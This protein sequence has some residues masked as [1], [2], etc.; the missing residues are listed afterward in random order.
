[1]RG[2]QKQ[3][4]YLESQLKALKTGKAIKPNAIEELKDFM[5]KRG[6]NITKTVDTTY[7]RKNGKEV[8]ANKITFS[9]GKDYMCTSTRFWRVV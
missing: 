7:Q 5:K 6:Y 3:I 8:K 1:M 9:N 2:K 4:K